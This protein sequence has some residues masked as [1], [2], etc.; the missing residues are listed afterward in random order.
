LRPRRFHRADK[1]IPT[2]N[3]KGEREEVDGMKVICLLSLAD[4]ACL[5]T[6]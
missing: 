5:I 3:A 2:V 1:K 4:A 6:T